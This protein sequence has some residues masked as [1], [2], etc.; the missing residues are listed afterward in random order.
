MEDQIP[1]VEVASTLP[2]DI[3]LRSL[4]NFSTVLPANTPN[5]PVGS[6]RMQLSQQEW[7]ELKPIIQKMYIDEGK[8]FKE[9]AVYLQTNHN[10]NP[11]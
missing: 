8:K 1:T 4:P 7:N 11:S 5:W 10:F 6:K 3:A 9:V 2:Y